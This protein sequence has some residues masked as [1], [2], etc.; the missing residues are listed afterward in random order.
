V[1]VAALAQRFGGG[2]HVKAAGA[3]LEGA[4]GAVQGT[5]LTAARDYVQNGAPG[6][7]SGS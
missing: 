7:G 4:M 5:V 3:S 2:G 6:E 1:D